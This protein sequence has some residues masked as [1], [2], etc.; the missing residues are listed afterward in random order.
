MTSPVLDTLAI[1]VLSVCHVAER[2]TSIG[3][4]LSERT[5]TAEYCDV[6]PADGGLPLIDNVETAEEGAAVVPVHDAPAAAAMTANAKERVKSVRIES[7]RDRGSTKAAIG[8]AAME[9]RIVR[10]L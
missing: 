6:F 5:A 2:V 7:W 8:I 1:A 10:V 9:H 3:V 4:V